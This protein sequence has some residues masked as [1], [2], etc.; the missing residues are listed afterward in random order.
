MNNFGPEAFLKLSRRITN[1]YSSNSDGVGRRRFL[2]IFGVT[3]SDCTLIWN[4][5]EKNV[6]DGASPTHLFWALFFLK[7][8]CVEEINRVVLGADEKTLRKWI[9]IMVDAIARIKVVI[10]LA[11]FYIL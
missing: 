6:P 7:N 1:H 3:P 5:I 4:H 8:Y 10:I 9:W 2:S 11:Y